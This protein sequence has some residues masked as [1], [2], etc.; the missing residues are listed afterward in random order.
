MNFIYSRLVGV[1]QENPK[2]DYMV[3]LKGIAEK[4]DSVP[5]TKAR[6]SIT[7]AETKRVR[8]IDITDLPMSRLKVGCWYRV[9]DFNEDLYT[10]QLGSDSVQF[11]KHRF[12]EEEEE[13]HVMAKEQ[14][15]KIKVSEFKPDG[16]EDA[17]KCHYVTT[18]N[19]DRVFWDMVMEI[20]R[21]YGSNTKLVTI[22][23]PEE[24]EIQSC[25]ITPRNTK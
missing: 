11:C 16:R 10:V 9:S 19:P 15:F 20:G 22:F 7:G 8:C 23:G 25:T 1:Y 5:H 3:A 6:L 13:E 12:E 2:V 4:I 14:N 24:V 17:V 18:D 21:K